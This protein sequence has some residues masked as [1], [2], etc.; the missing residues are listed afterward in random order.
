MHLCQNQ[1][2]TFLVCLTKT[3]WKIEEKFSDY[4]E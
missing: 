2:S 1:L 4:H 3:A